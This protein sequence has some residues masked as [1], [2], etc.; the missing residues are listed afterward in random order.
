MILTERA[1]CL[2][3]YMLIRKFL[4]FIVIYFPVVGW[5]GEEQKQKGQNRVCTCFITMYIKT[6]KK[7]D[8]ISDKSK[9]A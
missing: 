4:I 7:E 9:H 5:G 2:E 3:L 8:Q 6:N 1:C